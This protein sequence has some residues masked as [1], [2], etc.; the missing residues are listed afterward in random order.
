MMTREQLHIQIRQ[1]SLDDQAILLANVQ[2][3]LEQEYEEFDLTAEQYAELNRRIAD[4]E[5][6][7]S[8]GVLW[9]EIQTKLA[10]KY[11]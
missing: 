2:T 10:K 6:N 4:F 9:E 3:E 1:L 11:A 8:S 7:P 5:R